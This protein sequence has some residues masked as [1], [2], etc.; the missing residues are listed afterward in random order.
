MIHETWGFEDLSPHLMVVDQDAVQTF[1]VL[2]G[3]RLDNVALVVWSIKFGIAL[4]CGILQGLHAITCQRLQ[5]RILA[6][7]EPFPDVLEH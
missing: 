1:D 6:D 2:T 4:A 5:I 7:V 3:D